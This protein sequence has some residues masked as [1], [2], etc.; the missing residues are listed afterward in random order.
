MREILSLSL[1]MGT[2]KRLKKQ[3]KKNGFKTVSA[4]IQYLLSEDDTPVISAEELLKISKQTDK[5]Y[6]E[7]KTVRASSIS[8]LLEY[9]NK[10]Y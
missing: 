1:P 5:E 8:E 6:D 4:Y 10:K 7:G 9:D 3:T 2:K